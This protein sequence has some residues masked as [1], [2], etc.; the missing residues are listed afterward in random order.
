MPSAEGLEKYGWETRPAE[1]PSLRAAMGLFPTGVSVVTTGNGEGT[2]AMTANAVLSVSLDPL[3]FLV[4]VHKDARLN[5]RIR[6]EGYY[7]VSLLAADQE[8][9]SRLFSSPERSSGLPAVNSLGGGFG[10][11]GA[12]LAAGAMA[13]IE[14]ELETVYP[15]GDHALFLGRV[16]AVHMGDARKGPLV[17][18]EGSYPALGGAAQ[19]GGEFGAF[20]DS[21]RGFDARMGR[22]TPRGGRG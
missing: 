19:S 11:T 16:V 6:E 20:V 18:H 2:E 13:A 8:G 14:C 4:S 7:A 22:R 3:L 9:L 21:V 1:A 12:P 17:F 5:T 15:G 10:V